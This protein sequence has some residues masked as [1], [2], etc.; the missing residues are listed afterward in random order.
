M[1]SL[2]SWLSYQAPISSNGYI[3]VLNIA[4]RENVK[5]TLPVSICEMDFKAMV[6]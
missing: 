3:E 5:G 1:N 2:S 6:G 4:G